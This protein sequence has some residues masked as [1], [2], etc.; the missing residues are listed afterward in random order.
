MSLLESIEDP[1]FRRAVGL[2]EAGE[3]EPL[4]QH[5]AA[6]PGLATARVRLDE[7]GYFSQPSLLEFITENPIRTGRMPPNAVEVAR[8]LV[9]AGADETSPTALP[10]IKPSCL[11]TP[12]SSSFCW[13]TGPAW[14]LPTNFG[15]EHPLAGLAMPAATI[16]SRGSSM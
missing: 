4:R 7:P 13:L 16:W 14:K 15:T 10:C 2:M 12:R 3:V 5:L 11:D 6:H 8:T 9:E 1:H